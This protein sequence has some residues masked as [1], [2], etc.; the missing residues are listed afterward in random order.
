MSIKIGSKIEKL[1]PSDTYKLVDGADV[2]GFD[3]LKGRVDQHEADK[4]AIDSRVKTAETEVA[5]LQQSDTDLTNR[6]NTAEQ[7]LQTLQQN[8]STIAAIANGNT[9]AIKKVSDDTEAALQVMRSD[10]TQ[11]ISGI[12]V[13]D[14]HNHAID[15]ITML[16]FIGATVEDVALQNATVRIDKQLINVSNGQEPSSTTADV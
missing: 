14:I 6:V 7:H 8:D 15:D 9:A 11:K 16:H 13:E 1:N 4:N 2:E 12:H 10:I 3:T 5:A